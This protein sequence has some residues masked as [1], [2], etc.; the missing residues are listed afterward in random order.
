MSNGRPR[1]YVSIHQRLTATAVPMRT[2]RGTTDAGHR[3]RRSPG[4][5]LGWSVGDAGCSAGAAAWFGEAAAW[6]ASDAVCANSDIVLLRGSHRNCSSP[7]EEP[8]DHPRT[9]EP[10][11]VGAEATGGS[12]AFVPCPQTHRRRSATCSVIYGHFR[13]LAVASWLVGIPGEH[14][15]LNWKWYCHH[16]N[17]THD[18]RRNSGLRTAH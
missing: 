12:D 3:R 1:R 4:P 5:S 14:L 2:T 17:V 11:H 8:G 7:G 10:L 13:E 15:R 18:P 9:S 6:L 16:L